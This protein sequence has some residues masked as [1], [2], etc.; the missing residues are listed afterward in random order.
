MRVQQV[1]L[2]MRRHTALIHES[3]YL[4]NYTVAM[5]TCNLVNFKLPQL[6]HP[7]NPQQTLTMVEATTVTKLKMVQAMMVEMVMAAQEDL[8][9]NPFH[10]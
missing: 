5:V 3:A 8:S 7:T 2:S 10:L 6:A 4:I 9:A 1:L